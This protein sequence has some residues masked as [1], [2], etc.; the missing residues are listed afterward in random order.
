MT[1]TTTAHLDLA[2]NGG[3]ALCAEPVPFL[4]VRMEEEEKAA[5][6]RVLESGMLAQGP[7]CRELEESFA[8]ASQARF[9]VSCSNGTTALQLAYAALIKPGEEV[10]VPAWTFIATAS[11]VMARGATPVWC[12]VDPATYCVDP[13]DLKRKITGKTSAIAVT[14]LYGNPVD[15]AA[16]EALAKEHDL[17]VIYDA[18]Q[19]HLA[20]YDGRGVGAYGDACTYSFYATK[21]MTAGE[22]G[23]VTTNEEGLAEKLRSLRSHGETQKYLHERIGYNYRMNDMTAAIALAQLKKLPQ[24]T[25]RRRQIARL[26]DVGLAGISGLTLPMETATAECVYHLYTL[27]MEPSSFCCD[28]D[29][30]VEA[31]RAEGVGVAVHYPRATSRQPVFAETVAAHPPVADGLAERVFSIPL[32]PMLSDAQVQQVMEAVRKVANALKA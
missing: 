13:A 7:R 29:R 30:F 9:A 23:M 27:Q 8:Q 3:E 20:R 17:R 26:Y 2:I 1:A 21:N 15:I 11:M 12:D 28:R 22:G 32:H 14:H 4:V 6:L 10:L 25:E 24:R 31:L 18:A 16:V 19:A 5:V